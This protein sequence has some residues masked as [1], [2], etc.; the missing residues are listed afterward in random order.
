MSNWKDIDEKQ[1]EEFRIAY[2]LAQK[3]A[4]GE[5]L[6]LVLQGPP[7][8]GK[9]FIVYKALA[10]VDKWLQK[11]TPYVVGSRRYD[12]NGIWTPSYS[13]LKTKITPPALHSALYNSSWKGE[14]ILLDDCDAPLRNEESLNVL[15]SALDTNDPRIVTWSTMAKQPKDV[16]AEFIYSG[17]MIIITNIDFDEVRSPTLR[18]HLAALEDRCHILKLSLRTTEEKFVR[19]RSLIENDG[20]LKE[21]IPNPWVVYQYMVD[22]REKLDEISLRS[23]LKL[24]DLIRLWPVGWERIAQTTLWRR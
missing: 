21:L 4:L 3:V 23:A 22:N 2:E 9:S 14:T 7:G 17:G 20:F 10:D 24:A 16:P 6:G 12:G 19:I 8:L 11:K 18:D 1:R 5:I 15:K 13:I